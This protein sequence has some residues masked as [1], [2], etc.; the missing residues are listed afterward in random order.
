M[1]TVTELREKQATI[2]AE[3]RAAL[4]EIKSDTAE[5]RVAELE[6]Q[7]DRAM[8]EYD[9]L[10]ARIAREEKLAEREAVINAAD[11][12]RP[13]GENRSVKSGADKDELHR[14]AFET[15]LRNGASALSREQR[16][17]IQE[18]RAQGVSPDAKGGYLAPT[19][20]VARV[21]ESLKAYGPMLDDGV[22]DVINTG[23]GNDLEMPTEDDTANEGALLGENVQDTEQD[24]E[25]G[26]KTLGA[27]KYTTKIIRVSEELLQDL[28]DRC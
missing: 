13:L 20:F 26:Q 9:R 22:F 16:Q 27:Y 15:F 12:R 5:A 14:H 10:E 18:A 3:A 7:H 23:N 24:L 8:A 21:I 11:D 6:G 4:A 17:I 1:S 28:G 25:W 19:L 2:V